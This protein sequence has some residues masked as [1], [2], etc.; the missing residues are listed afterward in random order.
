LAGPPLDLKA[1]VGMVYRRFWLILTGFLTT[2]GII[3]YITFTQ[4]PLYSAQTVVQLDTQEK[5]VIDLGA[6]FSGLGCTTAVVDTEVMVLNPS[7]CSPGSPKSRSWLKIRNS[8][9]GF[10]RKRK[11]CCHPIRGFVKSADRCERQA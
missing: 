1:L 8:I 11:A 2:F 5:N 10:A 6:I 9:R 3:A 4:T 7:R